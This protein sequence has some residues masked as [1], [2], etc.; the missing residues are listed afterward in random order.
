M[1]ILLSCC[2]IATFKSVV[3]LYLALINGTNLNKNQAISYFIPH[4]VQVISAQF[5]IFKTT[6]PVLDFESGISYGRG[7]ILFLYVVKKDMWTWK[8]LS[9]KDREGW[10]WGQS[11]YF[12]AIDIPFFML[13]L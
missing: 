1:L 3:K 10:V 11:L 8:I 5:T 4:N 2:F 7:Y 9:C 12:I 6:F 13:M